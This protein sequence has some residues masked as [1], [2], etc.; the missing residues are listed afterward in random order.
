M[1]YTETFIQINKY[2]NNILNTEINYESNTLKEIYE[3]LKKNIGDE[4]I[5]FELNEIY[6]RF[7]LHFEN[8][9]KQIIF[10]MLVNL[11]IVE[12]NK[13]ILNKKK[14]TMIYYSAKSD[15]DS[16]YNICVE[17]M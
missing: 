15:I 3:L 4:D 8:E 2:I 16:N 12:I 17:L 10:T 11:I 13:K 9:E 5:V 1:S 7:H 14:L 6:N